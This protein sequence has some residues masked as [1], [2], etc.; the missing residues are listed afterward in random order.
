MK[1]LF[2]NGCSWT[3]GGGLDRPSRKNQ[4]NMPYEPGTKEHLEYI[5]NEI[6]W[7]AHVKKLMNFDKC[8]NLAEGCGSNQRICRTTFDWV[9]Q[10]DEETL[11][12]TTVIIQ[13]SCEDRY[14]YYVPTKEE[15]DD[16]QKRYHVSPMRKEDIYKKQVIN[17]NNYDVLHNLDRWAKVNPHGII[18]FTENH[19]DPH[20]I[21]QAQS[22]Y[23]TYTD[24]EAMY[25]WLFHM[26]FLYDFLTSKGIEC[27]YWYFNQYVDA[28]PQ[29]IQD[30][31][32]DRFP[33][34]E[35]DPLGVQTRCHLYDYER[36]GGDP[37][38]PHPSPRGHEQIGEYIVADIAKKKSIL[39]TP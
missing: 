32:Y 12:N 4:F 27:Y 37:Y 36:I 31:I 10:Q 33:M 24:Q 2:V 14:E 28:M 9:N 26:G 17:D 8:V 25:T 39:R 21:K 34:L 30:Y 20:V 7:P 16:F 5:H 6:V 13:W 23:Q 3:Y 29:E 11:K 18:S 1:T 15:Q 38:D 19:N 35:D 22:R